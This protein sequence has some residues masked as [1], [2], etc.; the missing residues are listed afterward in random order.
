MIQS[1]EEAG[2][3]I[4]AADDP[5]MDADGV[6]ASFA[7]FDGTSMGNQVGANA[8]ELFLVYGWARLLGVVAPLHGSQRKSPTGAAPQSRIPGAHALVA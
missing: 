6:E 5:I 8:A 4:M 2:I 7:G 3:P 1:A